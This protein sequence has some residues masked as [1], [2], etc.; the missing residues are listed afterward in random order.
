MALKQALKYSLLM[1]FSW[2]LA[3]FF[4]KFALKE[5]YDS[6]LL[7]SQSTVLAGVFYLIYQVSAGKI[8]ESAK[9]LANWKTLLLIG[10]I[11]GIGSVTNILGLSLSTSVN[12]GFLI[13]TTLVF[14]LLFSYF[15]LGEKITRT[16]ALIA[17]FMLTGSYLVSTGGESISLKQGDLFILFTCVCFAGSAVLLKKIGKKVPLITGGF[18]RLAFAAPF[19]LFTALLSHQNLLQ[20]PS[21]LYL[22]LNSL[23][24]FLQVFFLCKTMEIASPSFMSMI[25]NLVPVIVL[26]LGITFLGESLSLAQAIGGLIILACGFV[27]AKTN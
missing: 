13:R 14:T 2:S 9:A 24:L 21:L 3:V 10:L 11:G 26:V 22:F 8:P 4:G 27:A 20:V 23:F 25:N 1:A 18:Y 15:L 19:A 17:L 16:K 6:Y 12:Y 5:G 7:A